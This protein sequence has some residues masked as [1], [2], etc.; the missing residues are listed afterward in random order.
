M[1]ITF[2]SPEDYLETLLIT[3]VSAASIDVSTEKIPMT[4]RAETTGMTTIEPETEDVTNITE[5]KE[6]NKATEKVETG[7]QAQPL[8]TFHSIIM[9]V[10]CIYQ[11]K[12]LNSMFPTIFKFYYFTLRSLLQY[13]KKIIQRS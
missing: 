10:I 6:S 4:N 2:Y 11:V 7:K 5:E 3:T 8:K 12:F 9:I 1:F 13:L